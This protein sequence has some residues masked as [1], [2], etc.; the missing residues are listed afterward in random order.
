MARPK[1]KNAQKVSYNIDIDLLRRFKAY[2]DEKGQTQTVALERIIKEALD[3][4]EQEIRK[5]EI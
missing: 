2:C 3:K 1:T 4:H 5:K